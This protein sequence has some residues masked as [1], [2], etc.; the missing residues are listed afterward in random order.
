MPFLESIQNLYWIFHSAP[1]SNLFTAPK[2]PSIAC[3]PCISC[4]LSLPLH[5]H[6]PCCPRLR[7]LVSRC[8]FGSNMKLAWTAARQPWKCHRRGRE[9]GLY[10]TVMDSLCAASGISDALS[11]TRLPTVGPHLIFRRDFFSLTLF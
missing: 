2:I 8:Q 9:K 7:H 5:P 10:E 3:S 4:S 1:C 11:I 6:L